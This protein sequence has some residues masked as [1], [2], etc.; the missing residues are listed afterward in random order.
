MTEE[1]V[2]AW[3]AQWRDKPGHEGYLIPGVA[4]L[5]EVLQ[6]GGY[7]TIMSGK[8]HLGYKKDQIPGMCASGCV[9][10]KSS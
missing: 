9:F 10:Q 2:M 1:Q 4:A 5:P 8:W 3:G 6:D 7:H